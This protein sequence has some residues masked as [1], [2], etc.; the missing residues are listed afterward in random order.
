M[1]SVKNLNDG[2]E[3]IFWLITEND[4]S[5]LREL[6]GCKDLGDLDATIKDSKH[7]I[8]MADALGIPRANQYID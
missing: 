8:N 6:D 7:M 1:D 3:K 4:Y 5:E 2:L